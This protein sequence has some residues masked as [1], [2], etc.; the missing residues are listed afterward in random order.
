MPVMNVIKN[1]AYG[2][3]LCAKIPCED[4]NNG[5]QLIVAEYRKHF[6]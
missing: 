6:L 1:D 3:M 4:F 2:N 5:S